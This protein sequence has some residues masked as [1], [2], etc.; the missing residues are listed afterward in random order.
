MLGE[1]FLRFYAG[2]PLIDSNGFRLGSL[3]VLD[4]KPREF[5]AENCNVLCNFAEVVVR[6]IEKDK[7]RV[8]ALAA[9][10]T[11]SVCHF[12]V[13]RHVAVAN[14]GLL[15]YC[16]A[17]GGPAAS[18][19]ARWPHA[20]CALQELEAARV[21]TEKS[22]LLR[23]MDCFTEGV[24]LLNVVTDDFR[25]MFMNNSWTRITGQLARSV[26]ALAMPRAAGCT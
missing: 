17:S 6:E 15:V 23:A 10:C 22:N 14:T 9:G 24:M 1:P 13:I 20:C 25:I 11:C 5:D 7:R 26:A 8:S 2:A 21:Q 3:C 18:L 19:R 12:T 4:H 16:L